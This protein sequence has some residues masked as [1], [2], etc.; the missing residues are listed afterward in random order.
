[1]SRATTLIAATAAVLVSLGSLT[2]CEPD[3][4]STA[5]APPS[6]ASTPA[7]APA[8]DSA[9]PS[10]QAPTATSSAGGQGVKGLPNPVWISANNIPLYSAYH[11]ASP[12]EAAKTAKDPKFEF[13]SLCRSKRSTDLDGVTSRATAGQAL[14]GSGGGQ[15]WQAKETIVNWPGKSSGAVQTAAALF[16]GLVDELKAC[17]TSAPG[18]TVKVTTEDST[19]LVAT[20][21]VPQAG[22]ATATLHQYLSNTSATVSE[23]ALWSAPPAGGRP[24]VAWSAPS[25]AGVLKTL[26][27]P[28]CSTFQDC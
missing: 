19:Y 6:T 3:D 5:A 28:L 26:E 7:S 11:W 20:I 10:G 15:D 23:L 16:R 25:D 17:G 4:A 9:S 13:E 2:A 8:Q 21:T 27:G 24:K 1:M 22:G 18:A 12:A 14:L